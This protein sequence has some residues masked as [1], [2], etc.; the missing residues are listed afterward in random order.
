MGRAD[1]KKRLSGS[2]LHA[3]A[4]LRWLMLGAVVVLLLALVAA[5]A[6]YWW[7][8]RYRP[9]LQPGE[10]YGADISAWQGRIDWPVL[11]RDDIGFAYIKATEGRNFVDREFARNW[12]GA[13][14]AGI[15]HGAYHYFSLC[16]SGAAQA[17]NFLHV[18]PRDKTALAPELDLEL[19]GNCR[20][21]PALSAVDTQLSSFLDRVQA[22]TGMTV[23][24]YL[25]HDWAH[26]YPLP[27]NL[28]NPLWEQSALHPPSGK[29][30]VIWQVDGFAH[31]DGITGNVDLDVM[32]VAPAG[33]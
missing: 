18:V 14:K 26:R 12:A 21:R 33:L 4:R 27:A 32:R 6:W 22:Q 31:L 29:D 8:P 13:A 28:H 24:I 7:L 5:G 20:R 9:A 19:A 16:D 30:W 3:R 10:R 23:V 15:P 25:G 11:A 2:D 17:A 1:D